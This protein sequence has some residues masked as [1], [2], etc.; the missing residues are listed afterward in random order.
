MFLIGTTFGYEMSIFLPDLEST[1]LPSYTRICL[2]L[3]IL[4]L[5]Q[6]E[7]VLACGAFCFGLSLLFLYLC[8]M[9]RAWVLI[10]ALMKME[11][12]LQTDVHTLCFNPLMS[13]DWCL[14]EN[15][16]LITDGWTRTVLWFVNEFSILLRVR[17][18]FESF[19]LHM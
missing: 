2:K 1:M 12:W 17:I 10:C 8:W 18:I 15:R 5:G 13:F 6:V 19:L 4:G 14:N 11:S 9:F 16:V 3:A 7:N